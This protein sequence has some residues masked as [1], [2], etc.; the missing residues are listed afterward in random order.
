MN[1]FEEMIQE[2]GRILN[3]PLHAEKNRLCKLNINDV[4]H[5]QIEF[6]EAKERILIACFVCDLP[7]GKFREN[8]LKEALKANNQFPSLG[9][10]AYS[11][12][13]NKLA[14]FTHFPIATIN[15]NKLSEEL[16]KFIDKTDQWRMAVETGQLASVAIGPAKE[17]PPFGLKT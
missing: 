10:L 16:M 4:L 14:L 17:K 5:I 13:N 15:A 12:K 9:T 8:V 2:M 6:D 11:E 7:P 1:I 3:V